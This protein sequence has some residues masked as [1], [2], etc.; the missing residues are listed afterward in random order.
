M[1]RR[2]CVLF[3]TTTIAGKARPASLPTTPSVV[4]LVCLSALDG[5]HSVTQSLTQE[6]GHSIVNTRHFH[7]FL[8]LSHIRYIVKRW[9]AA[10]KLVKV[11]PL[12]F[13]VGALP[14]K[15]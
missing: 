8:L 10:V 4:V 6:E 11:S 12:L 2:V 14:T 7:I 15:S 13:V 5:G 9:G 3:V 1:G